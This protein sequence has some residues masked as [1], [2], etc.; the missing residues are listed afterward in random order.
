MYCKVAPIEMLLDIGDDVNVGSDIDLA[1]S[2]KRPVPE[3]IL[4]KFHITM[5]S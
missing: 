5:T 4:T 2:G 1:L 3:S